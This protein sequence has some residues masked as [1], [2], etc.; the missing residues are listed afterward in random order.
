MIHISRLS[1]TQVLQPNNQIN[2][3]IGIKMSKAF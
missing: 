3:L 2:P 1:T